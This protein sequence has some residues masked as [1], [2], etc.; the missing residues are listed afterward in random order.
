MTGPAESIGRTRV[1]VV[2]LG[3]IGESIAVTLVAAGHDVAAFDLRADRLERAVRAGA[4]ASSSAVAAASGRDVVFTALPTSD[5]VADVVAGGLLTAMT[6][7]SILVDVTTAS[8]SAQ[9]ELDRACAASGVSFLEMP[10]S[11]RAPHFAAFVGGAAAVLERVAPLIAELTDVA[12]HLGPVG[13]GSRAKIVH[14]LMAFG[15][16]ALACEALAI[17]TRAGLPLDSFVPALQRSRAAS[18]M[19]PLVELT[20]LRRDFG[21]HGGPLA[22]IAKDMRLVRGL[23][24]DLGVDS[25][26]VDVVTDAYLAAE[27]AGWGSESA[28]AVAKVIEA[29]LGT[30]IAPVTTRLA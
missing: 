25:V 9:L 24:N 14:Q 1:G 2:G 8:P 6:P 3:P 17:A 13:S 10:V 12:V 28:A 15:N 26:F 20:V 23:A 4:R 11:G 27:A 29:R 7:A 18:A 30:Q 21:D 16:F 19:L 5:H 22:Q